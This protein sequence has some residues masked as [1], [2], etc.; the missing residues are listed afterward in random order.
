[1]KIVQSARNEES[2]SSDESQSKPSESYENKSST[3][4]IMHFECIE[5]PDDI[6]Q[7]KPEAGR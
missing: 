3:S 5:N 4:H 7:N 1:M 2:G 6:D